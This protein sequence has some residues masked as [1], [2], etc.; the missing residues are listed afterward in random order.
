MNMWPVRHGC[1]D[2]EFY[3]SIKIV[4]FILTEDHVMKAM[5]RAV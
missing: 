5:E 2:G 4:Q 3:P 1:G